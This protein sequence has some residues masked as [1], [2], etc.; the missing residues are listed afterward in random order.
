[1]IFR[2]QRLFGRRTTAQDGG[3]CVPENARGSITSPSLIYLRLV[4]EEVAEEE[5]GKPKGWVRLGAVFSAVMVGL[6]AGMFGVFSADDA[7]AAGSPL[8]GG[9][10]GDDDDVDKYGGGNNNTATA[11][12]T[13]NLTA[14]VPT[15]P[16]EPGRRMEE[17]ARRP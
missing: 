11:T 6:S 1:M 3:A 13:G 8:T 14:Q 15:R 17:P 2:N 7:L 16:P 10:F 12:G 5:V 4:E 9:S